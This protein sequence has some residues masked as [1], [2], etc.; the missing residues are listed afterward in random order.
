MSKRLRS[1]TK[2]VASA[3]RLTIAPA[4]MDWYEMDKPG[5]DLRWKLRALSPRSARLSQMN[6]EKPRDPDWANDL[7]HEE[8]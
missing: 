2:R 5:V 1:A 7:S 8:R 4:M 6:S 3:M